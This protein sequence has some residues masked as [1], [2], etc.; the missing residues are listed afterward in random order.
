[1]ADQQTVETEEGEDENDEGDEEDDNAEVVNKELEKGAEE[2]K[3][4][5][6]LD[7]AVFDF[8]IQSWKQKV[9]F[10]VAVLGINDQIGGWVEA[11]YYTAKLAGLVW[12]GRMLMLEHIFEGQ[13]DNPEEM[14]IAM[15]E[16]FKEQYRIWLADGSHTPFS[17][18]IRWMSYEKGYRKKKGGMAK[19]L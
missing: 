3:A 6:A 13:S 7:R 2:D 4:Q 5:K 12:C 16:E 14:S 9:A 18:I 19:V 8:Y 17:T 1:M 15:V 11:K 10:K